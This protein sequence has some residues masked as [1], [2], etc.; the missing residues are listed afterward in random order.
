MRIRGEFEAICADDRW[1]KMHSSTH[2]AQA[3]KAE[4]VR[5]ERSISPPAHI[6]FDG[7]AAIVGFKGISQCS[8]AHVD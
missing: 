7:R 2:I 8:R 1:P 5:D 3:K 6:V 4:E